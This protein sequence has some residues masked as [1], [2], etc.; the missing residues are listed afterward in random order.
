[1]GGIPI[2]LEDALH[3]SPVGHNYHD[4]IYIR[5]LQGLSVQ[6]V[7]DYSRPAIGCAFHAIGWTDYVAIALSMIIVI[8]VCNHLNWQN[9]T[10]LARPYGSSHSY[11][12][13]ASPA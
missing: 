12:P 4:L 1:M 13:Q 8:N 3:G 9:A 7:L 6:D 10:K 11:D 5:I 2:R